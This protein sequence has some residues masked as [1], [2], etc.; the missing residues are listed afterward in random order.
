[1]G[2]GNGIGEW[3]WRSEMGRRGRGGVWLNRRGG[4]YS[5]GLGVSWG[6]VE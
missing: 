1:M 4:D 2:V 6:G 5:C 3:D